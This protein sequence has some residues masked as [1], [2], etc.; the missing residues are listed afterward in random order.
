ME[1]SKIEKREKVRQQRSYKNNPGVSKAM[2]SRV[3]GGEPQ[4][5]LVKI[6]VRDAHP[7]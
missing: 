3:L 6:Q 2:K 5:S 1:F 4:T 7:S